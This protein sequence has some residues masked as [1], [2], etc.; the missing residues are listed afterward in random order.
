MSLSNLKLKKRF[1]KYKKKLK[2]QYQ[3]NSFIKDYKLI[4][5]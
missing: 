4:N 1:Q 2:L 3:I 5:E